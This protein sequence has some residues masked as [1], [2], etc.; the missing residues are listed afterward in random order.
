MFLR[1]P[2][3]L[4]RLRTL[5]EALVDRRAPT[6][7]GC[8]SLAWRYLG[9]AFGLDLG[10]RHQ[11][12]P[13][14]PSPAG[15][16][17]ALPAALETEDLLCLQAMLL[18]TGLDQET[19]TRLVPLPG[20]ELR[21]RLARLAELGL[22]RTGEE[23]WSVTPGSYPAL[24]RALAQAGFWIDELRWREAGSRPGSSAV[25]A[26]FHLAA[27]HDAGTVQARL[28]DVAFASALL[29]IER[30]VTVA[31]EEQVWGT[32]YRL[33]AE[34]VRR[35]LG[36]SLA[37]DLTIRGKALLLGLGYR[38]VTAAPAGTEAGRAG[39]DR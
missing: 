20:L 16:V 26:F 31:V 25:T 4:E 5:L 8:G 13:A 6:I 29:A 33:R 21:L 11:L 1:T 18:H 38:P 36:A 7:V 9:A 10:F 39:A 24:R 34:P 2:A 27:D 14:P 17:P 19:L 28:R 37:S 32:S 15:T 23:G 22:I 12:V 35:E 3:G 30:P